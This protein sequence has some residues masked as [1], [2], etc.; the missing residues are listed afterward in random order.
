VNSA[1][2]TPPETA[3]CNVCGGE[4]PAGVPLGQCPRCL[5][6]LALSCRSEVTGGED[7]GAVL[8]DTGLETAFDFEILER[9]GQGGMGVV[10][11]A[12]QRSLDRVVALKVIRMGDLASPE[13]LGRFRREAE[14]AAKLDHPDIVAIYQ[15]GEREANPYLVMQLVEGA[16]L[17]ERLSEF[18]LPSKG[19]Q[20]DRVQMRI[21]R[22]I[23]RVA[24]AVH[25]AHERG[26]LHRDLKPSN[27]LLDGEGNPHLTDFGI[28]KLLDHDAALTQTAELLGTPCYMAP[29]Q[30]EGRAVSR[31]ADIYSLGAVL[32]QLLSGRPPF[33]GQTPMEILRKVLEEDPPHPGLENPAVD[34]DLA[35]ICL[36]C[37][38]KDPAHRYAS[39]LELAQDLERW[40][41]REPILAREAGWLLRLRRWTMRNPAVAALIVTLTAGMLTTLAL[42]RGANEEKTRK[43]IALDI[44]RA[45]SARQLQEIWSSPSAFFAIKS[46]TL[47]TMA[48]MEVRDLAANEQRLA[49]A[50]VVE[51]N[52]LDR[53]LRVAPL[54]GEL[55]R[56]LSRLS[57]EP[58]RLDL[59][60]YK[61]HSSAIEGFLKGEIDMVRLS[62]PELLR[63]RAR[64]PKIR[65]LI[66][67]RPAPG[68]ND[69]AVIF[70]RKGAG[71]GSLADLRGK[72]LL[73]GS[74]H[75]TLSFWTK[76]ALVDAGIRSGDLSKYR[77]ID[78]TNDVL[79]NGDES[80]AAVI[81]N[82]FSA[83]TP[84]EAVANGIYDAAV[85]RE[86]RFRE[87]AV[88][89]DLVALQRFQDSGEILA[90]RG[91]LPVKITD[92]FQ[93]AMLD[94]GD[95][96]LQLGF[97]DSPARVRAATED[98]LRETSSKLSAETSFGP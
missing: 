29:E 1:V 82:P 78:R 51:G 70:A 24:R 6:D 60:L 40:S 73:L 2:A 71:I 58:T 55:E 15:I 18:D 46:E 19:T 34:L 45:E 56:R 30:A 80:A 76:V 59:R 52:P 38:D 36:K 54:L 53:A 69:S 67:I 87:V 7:D 48:G 49:F 61:D 21:A 42:L 28:A 26:V 47:S 20:V 22:L 31:G 81:G 8:P 63:A 68:F 37:L 32:Y 77:Y 94:L 91:S 4:I 11:R 13:M 14:M 62:A 93:R 97:L 84:V 85:V 92:A 9:I 12:H 79:P 90:A 16:S 95:S 50:L 86:K 64:D 98:D 17:A 65:P 35:T 39:A 72:S 57:D 27:I 74:T 33:G 5:L 43:T 89:L 23:A 44:L 25:F 75:S 10:Y 3:T 41:R 83:M 88:E 96:R 66:T